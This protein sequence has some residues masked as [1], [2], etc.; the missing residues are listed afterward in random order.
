MRFTTGDPR[1]VPGKLAVGVGVVLLMAHF[2]MA[3]PPAH[4]AA[5]AVTGATQSC[6]MTH[7]AVG[8]PC[9]VAP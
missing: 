7:Y 3:A 1:S 9:F 6:V 5:G 8:V 4:I 2:A